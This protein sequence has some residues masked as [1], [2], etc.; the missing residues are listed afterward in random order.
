MPWLKHLKEMFTSKKK[1]RELFYRHNETLSS[2]DILL[3]DTYCLCFHFRIV[4]HFLAKRWDFAWLARV[5]TSTPSPPPHSLRALDTSLSVF[6][7]YILTT[8]DGKTFN[9]SVLLSL[10]CRSSASFLILYFYCLIPLRQIRVC[11]CSQRQQQRREEMKQKKKKLYEARSL[12]KRTNKLVTSKS[13]IPH[14]WSRFMR[15]YIED[16]LKFSYCY[17]FVFFSL[18]GLRD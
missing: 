1:L 5:Q 18:F 11:F 10:F 17:W 9:S 13:M 14:I 2:L 12:I 6:F 4:R 3:L 15:R 7:F 8:I 16:R